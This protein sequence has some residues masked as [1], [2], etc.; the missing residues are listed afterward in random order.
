LLT[1]L[2]QFHSIDIIP[3][4]ASGKILRRNMRDLTK[5]L[6]PESFIVKKKNASK[7]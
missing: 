2:L 3:K 5:S 1:A 7:L 4:T 6:P